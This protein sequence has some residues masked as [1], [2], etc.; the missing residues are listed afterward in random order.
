MEEEIW[1]NIKDY[2]GFYQASNFGR[3]R[4]IPH[5]AN[6]GYRSKIQRI[7]G[8]VLNP[9]PNDKGYLRVFLSKNNKVKTKYVHILIAQTF[10]PNLE[11]KPQVNHIDCNKQNNRVDNLEWCTGLENMKHAVKNRLLKSNQKT[12]YQYDENNNLIRIWDSTMQIER[13]LGIDHRKISKI[14]KIKKQKIDGLCFSYIKL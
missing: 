7:K 6:G 8:K 1:K 11:N 5:I 2:E 10:I 12:V 13:E 4:S 3:I 9:T 14:C